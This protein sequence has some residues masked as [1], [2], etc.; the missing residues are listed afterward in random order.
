MKW[1]LIQLLNRQQKNWQKTL[2]KARFEYDVVCLTKKQK[3][4]VLE[5]KR[6]LS[7]NINLIESLKEAICEKTEDRFI[8]RKPTK[9]ERRFYVNIEKLNIKKRTTK[10]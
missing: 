3:D 1:L 7:D 4:E 6:I 2:D 9:D 5:V 10:V 8:G